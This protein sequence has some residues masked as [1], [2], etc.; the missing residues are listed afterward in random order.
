[1]L[2]PPAEAG[3]II[4]GSVNGTYT[5]PGFWNTHVNPGLTSPLAAVQAA[6]RPVADW[7]CLASTNG[8]AGASAMGLAPVHSPSPMVAQHLN[9][10]LTSHRTI[11]LN[12][13]GI[14]RPGLTNATFNAGIAD[15]T[16]TLDNNAQAAIRYQRDRNEKTFT[17]KHGANLAQ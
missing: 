10:S 7:F 14:G 13:A 17:D 6:W 5:L 11:I 1:M 2:L 16:N 4:S 8:N 9:T 12:R 3:D 15:L